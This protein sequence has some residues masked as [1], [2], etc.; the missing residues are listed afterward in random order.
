MKL[1]APVICLLLFTPAFGKI[2]PVGANEAVKKIGQAVQAAAS[3]DT[4]LIKK[5]VYYVENVIISKPVTLLGE[6]RPVLHGSDK[7]EIFTISGTGVTVK[8]IHFT[9]SGYSSANDYAAITIIDASNFV[10]EDNILTQT[11][12][13]IH[14]ANSHHFT[15][16]GNRLVGKTKSEQT[17]GNGIH[18]WKC[19][20]AV[21]ENNNSSGHRDGIYFEFVTNSLIKENVSHNNI[22]YGLHF[23]F[24]NDDVYSK[25]TFEANGAGVAVMFSKRVTM[26][27]NIFENNWGPSAYGILL[28]EITDSKINGS[29]FYRNTVAIYMEGANRIEIS[30]NTF[31]ENGWASKVQASCSDNNFHHNNFLSNTFDIATNGSLVLNKFSDNYWDKYEG[32]DIN[33]DGIGDVPYHPVSMYSMLIEQNPNSLLLLRSFIITLLDKAE[34]A[35]PSLTPETLRDDKPRMRQLAI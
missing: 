5:G 21:I 18:L 20:N 32:Y 14:V 24:S 6:N 3:G 7:Y 11:F 16:K 19:S 34:K 1:M 22:R 4:I 29:K 17:S 12:F 35:I 10:I 2:I 9:N 25:N 15:I 31:R 27:E 26:N 28:K 30:N 13:G 33:R 23:M 8:G